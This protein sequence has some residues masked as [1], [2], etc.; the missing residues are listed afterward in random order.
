MTM[1]RANRCFLYRTLPFSQNQSR[2]A[3]CLLFSPFENLQKSLQS[4]SVELIILFNLKNTFFSPTL[5]LV[6]LARNRLPSRHDGSSAVRSHAR[7][8]HG[9]AA[10]DH[11]RHHVEAWNTRCYFLRKSPREADSCVHRSKSELAHS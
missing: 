7:G 3:S 2:A 11:P 4:F 6:Q 10:P 5:S 1:L 9:A 8:Q